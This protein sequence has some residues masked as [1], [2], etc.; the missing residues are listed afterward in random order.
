MQLR[1]HQL[2]ICPLSSA[3]EIVSGRIEPLNINHLHNTLG[4][5]SK[6]GIRSNYVTKYVDMQN[7]HLDFIVWFCIQST[8]VEVVVS[9]Y[10]MATEINETLMDS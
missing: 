3:A 7:G 5:I 9:T 2:I 10:A 4:F 1:T 8:K 6:S